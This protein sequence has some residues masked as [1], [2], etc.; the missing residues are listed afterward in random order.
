MIYMKQGWNLIVLIDLTSN[1]A[2]FGT[3]LH[4]FCNVPDFGFPSLSLSLSSL[5]LHIYIYICVSSLSQNKTNL[6]LDINVAKDYII[7]GQILLIRPLSWSFYLSKLS[8]WICINYSFKSIQQFIHTSY[9]RSSFLFVLFMLANEV[10]MD[11]GVGDFFF[12]DD[13]HNEMMKF[14]DGT[15]ELCS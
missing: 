2:L 15:D 1:H 10:S 9:K 4:T 6:P 3:N 13:L 14:S 7:Q 5:S 11:D 8:D 12:F